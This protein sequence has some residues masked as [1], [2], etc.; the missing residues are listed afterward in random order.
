MNPPNL[1]RNIFANFLGR[2]WSSLI[3]LIFV[4]VYVGFL[5]VEAY[6][7]I[8]VYA[9]LIGVLSVLD[10]GL[11]ATLSRELARLSATPGTEDESRD[12]F[13]TMEV[14]YWGI[15]LGV[16][17]LISAAAPL[18]AQHWITSVRIPPDVVR[19]A[20]RLMG[21]VAALEWPVALYSGGL[22]GLQRQ[23][24]INVVR[25]GAGTTQALGA[26]VILWVVSPT[27][28]AYFSWQVVVAAGQTF[29]LA[30]VAWR[31]LPRGSRVAAFRTDLLGK[32]SRFAAG[33]T[34]IAGLTT[35][36]TQVDKLVL[37]KLVTLESFGYYALATGVA[38]AAVMLVQPIYVAVFPRFAQ[39]AMARDHAVTASLYH[40]TC[41]LVAIVVLP[42][43]LTI[44]FFSREILE[45]WLRNPATAGRT[46][47]LLTVFVVGSGLNAIMTIPYGLQLAN[48]WTRLSLIKNAA[49]VVVSVPLLIWLAGRYGAVGAAAVWV[50]LNAAYV[51]LEVPYMH[52]RLLPGEMGRWY[53]RDNML[54]AAAAVAVCIAS[55]A[56]MPATLA[57]AP[58][59]F[60]ICA[61]W[62]GAAALATAAS[63]LLSG[64][65][66]SSYVRALTEG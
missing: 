45:L 6:G 25:A 22:M 51:L 64:G 48:G 21:V 31:S 49:A 47:V 20:I 23:V 32:N 65:T 40:K 42:V 55:R 44:A 34:G 43:A 52:R 11:S 15:G 36:L 19:T 3:G 59:L 24:P 10:L 1:I 18:I 7:L 61:T 38:T 57:G 16:G 28:F 4:P 2:G 37:T 26:L 60:W 9:S 5:G 53:V 50:A 33:M 14:V 46:H 66:L 62:C 13:R 30:R 27:V 29:V 39:L 17:L 56:L 54:P 58:V 8:G 41:Q 35:I 63:G 12:L